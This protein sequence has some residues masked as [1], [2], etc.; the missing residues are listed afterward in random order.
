M[1]LEIRHLR[2]LQA[3]HDTGSLAQAAERLH[4][5]QSALSHQIKSIE[6][7]FDIS[8][9]LRKHKPLK[10]TA[11]GQQ[12]LQLA[13]QVLPQVHNAEAR[14]RQQSL[15]ESGRLHIAVE[16]HSCFEWLMP[17]LDI[18]RQQWMDVEVDI[19]S[20][21]SFDPVPALSRGEIDLVITSDKQDVD[22]I[23]FTPLFDFE[24]RAVLPNQ[25]PLCEKAFIEAEDFKHETLLIYPVAQQ[26]LDIFS[27]LLNPAGIVPAQ[28]RQ[29]ELTMMM[30]QLVA[31]NRGIAVLP[32]WLLRDYVQRQYITSKP[33]GEQGMKG[34]L[35]AAMREPDADSAYMQAFLA[36]SM[37]STQA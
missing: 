23:V 32:D 25:H 11:A 2:S 15:G 1:F 5:T 7:Y 31:S 29:V 35:Y 19:R 18:Y 4:L 16:C 9:Y 33:I 8:L 20:G 30:L 37:K 6:H 28:V 17:A 27:K 22:G 36:L 3:I 24:A 12:L 34:Q 13:Q 21:M 26:R 14:L 10:L